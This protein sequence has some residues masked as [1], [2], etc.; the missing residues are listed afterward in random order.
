[1]MM[2][3]VKASKSANGKKGE[4]Q[5]A[6]GGCLDLDS[7][8]DSDSEGLPNLVEAVQTRPGQARTWTRNWSSARLS[9][10]RALMMIKCAPDF[11]ALGGY[12]AGGARGPGSQ[13]LISSFF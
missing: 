1:M 10:Y 4:T 6:V 12:M 11:G 3:N 5:T 2:K 13:A 7:Y 9:D 8:S